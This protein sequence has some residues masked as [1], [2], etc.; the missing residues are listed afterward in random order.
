MLFSTLHLALTISHIQ[1]LLSLQSMQLLLLDHCHP[2]PQKLMCL[3]V[4]L[5]SIKIEDPQTTLLFCRIFLGWH[6]GSLLCIFIFSDELNR[7]CYKYL[8][9]F[10]VVIDVSQNNLG[11]C[12]EL[13]LVDGSSQLLSQQ[14]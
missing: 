7:V 5:V 11:I 4:S 1:L 12:P 14:Q 2:H 3:I 10:V 8:K 6:I 9:L 13:F